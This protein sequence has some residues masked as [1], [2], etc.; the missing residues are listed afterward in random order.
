MKG[1]PIFYPDW[2]HCPKP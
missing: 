2:R 1:T